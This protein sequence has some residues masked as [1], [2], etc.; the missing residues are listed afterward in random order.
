MR[1]FATGAESAAANVS[2]NIYP[3]KE[4]RLF[5]HF[6]ANSVSEREE[7]RPKWAIV[8]NCLKLSKIVSN[9]LILSQIVSNCSKLS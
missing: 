8:S 4:K 1:V 2:G 3:L 9:F 5:L 7:V 6:R